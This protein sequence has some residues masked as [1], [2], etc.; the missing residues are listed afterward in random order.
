MYRDC[1]ELT[2]WV[3]HGGSARAIAIDCSLVPSP[4]SA[5]Q[6]RLSAPTESKTKRAPWQLNGAGINSVPMQLGPWHQQPLSKGNHHEQ[7]N[8]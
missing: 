4:L 7:Q 5:F 6:A 3:R 1:H 8:P 2:P